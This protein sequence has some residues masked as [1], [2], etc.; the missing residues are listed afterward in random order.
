MTKPIVSLAIVALFAVLFSRASHAQDRAGTMR[1]V[2]KDAKGAPVAGAF[3]KL[4]NGERRL[5]FMIVSQ[6]QGRYSVSNL[7]SGSYVAQAIGG[8]FQSEP[9]APVDVADGKSATADLALTSPRA[10]QLPG[11]WP[12]G[13]P[14]SESAKAARVEQYLRHCLKEKVNRSSK[15]IASPAMMPN[16]SRGFRPI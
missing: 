5:T 2:V 8:D 15:P 4:K 10:A 6:A 16:E 3:V 1:G 12:A 9:S 13:S 7:P 11:A 14:A